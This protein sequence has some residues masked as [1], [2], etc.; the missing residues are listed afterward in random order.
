MRIVNVLI[1]LLTSLFLTS[2]GSTTVLSVDPAL[3]VNCDKPELIGK[4]WRDLAISYVE[5]GE[6]IDEC[7]ARMKL[8][9]ESR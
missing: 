3:V 1:L 4:T 5:R 8:L 6:A 7:N 2:C 9:R